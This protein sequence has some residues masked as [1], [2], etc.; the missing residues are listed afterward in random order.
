LLRLLIKW[1]FLRAVTAV[2]MIL[3]NRYFLPAV[4]YFYFH[5]IVA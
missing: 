4:I 5:V 1:Q 3:Q 2:N